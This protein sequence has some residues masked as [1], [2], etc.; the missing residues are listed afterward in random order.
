MALSHD[1][2]TAMMGGPDGPGHLAANAPTG[3]GKA[4]AAGLPAFLMAALRGER[5]VVSTESKALQSQ[6]VG[7]DYPLVADVVRDLTGVEVTFAMH[8]G[9]ANFVCPVAAMN[10]AKDIFD[11]LGMDVP[12][13]LPQERYMRSQSDDDDTGRAPDVAGLLTGVATTLAQITSDP[14]RAGMLSFDLRVDEQPVPGRP[15][16]ELAEWATLEAAVGGSGDRAEFPGDSSEKLWRHVSVSPDDCIGAKCPLYDMCPAI[17]AR[18]QAGQAEVAVTNHTLLALQAS[19]GVPT[20]LSNN[21][22]GTFA[23]LVVDEAHTLPG[24]VRSSGARAI[25]GRRL[26]AIAAQLDKIIGSSKGGGVRNVRGDALTDQAKAMASAIDST[27]AGY[28]LGKG[29]GDVRFT[30]LDHPL[31]RMTSTIE[32]WAESVLEALPSTAKLTA[33]RAIIRIRRARFAVVSLLE[34]LT[35]SLDAD[36]QYARWVELRETSHSSHAALCISPVDVAPGISWNLF[37]TE[38]SEDEAAKKARKARGDAKPPRLP[39]SVTMMSAT[40]PPAFSREAGIRSKVNEYASPFDDAYGSSL[41]FVPRVNDHETLSSIG[42][43][44]ANGRSWSLDVSLHPAWAGRTIVDLVRANGGR[45]LVLS[46]TAT[47]GKLYA[48][49]LRGAG[50]GH[51]VYSQWDGLDSQQIVQR[52]RSDT[53]SVLVG[54]RSMMTGVDAAGDTC[55]LVIIDRAPRNPSNVVDE[56]RAEILMQDTDMDKWAADRAVYVSDAAL[57]L[58][59]AAGRLIRSVSD[60]GLVAVLDPRLMKGTPISYPE[61]TRVAYMQALKRF[62][63]RTGSSEVAID[64]LL[65]RRAAA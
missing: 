53:S 7:K 58:T 12:V 10:A 23:H 28:L 18:E 49:L 4:L 1:I 22:L 60:S 44:R 11:S 33:S 41:L 38:A 64:Y 6:L 30:P 48:D 16:V 25:S 29:K 14:K 51:A 47:N 9:F 45:A 24:I 3:V 2:L 63:H 31:L 37:A 57:L 26:R 20:V 35:E 39:L 61:S 62:V 15:I 55:T 40:L 32:S 21:R 65:E 50:T 5:V 34:D 59:Q 43:R 52:W 42:R 27:L 13:E 54:T 17:A 36:K 46:S 56:A 8:K 19:L